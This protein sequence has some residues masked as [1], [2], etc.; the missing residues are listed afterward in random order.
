MKQ[1]QQQPRLLHASET[2]LYNC[3]K[4]N[5]VAQHKNCKQ[6]CMMIP[7]V[8]T[9]SAAANKNAANIVCQMECKGFSVP[10]LPLSILI[11]MLIHNN[12]INFISNTTLIS[13][14]GVRLY[15]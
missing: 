10:T 9:D 8:R 2:T 5:N 4:N 7:G 12:S 14:C 1:E 11:P 6:L 15:H 3:C 13:M